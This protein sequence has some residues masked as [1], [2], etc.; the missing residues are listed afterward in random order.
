MNAEVG[1]AAVPNERDFGAASMRNAE[2]GKKDGQ[3]L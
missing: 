1:P 3:G 2:C